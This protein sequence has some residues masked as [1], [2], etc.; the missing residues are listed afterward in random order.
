MRMRWCELKKQYNEMQSLVLQIQMCLYA[1]FN[2][3]QYGRVGYCRVGVGERTFYDDF[4]IILD[5][6]K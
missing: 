4:K 5:I 6:K 1:Y 2:A 3:C